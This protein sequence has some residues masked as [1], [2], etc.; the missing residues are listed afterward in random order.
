ML[1]KEFFQVQPFNPKVIPLT[2]VFQKNT[3]GNYTFTV[4]NQYNYVEI[5]I[6][7]AAGQKVC[8]NTN[9][10]Y[11]FLGTPGKGAIK[12]YLRT[13]TNHNITGIVGE[14]PTLSPG[15]TQTGGAGYNNG[16]N[17]S[18]N[19]NT[20]PW[21]GGGGGSTSFVCNGQLFTVGGGGGCAR[22]DGMSS[23]INIFS[24]N[25]GAG[26]GPNGGAA[27]YYSSVSTNQVINGKNATNSDTIGYN[28]NNG[29]VK[30]FAGFDPYL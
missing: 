12:R 22:R 19:S 26:G 5:E 13:L 16:S 7:G 21:G 3:P 8:Y 2:L 9:S 27:S 4:P 11:V 30:I 29:Y 25:G 14:Q 1:Q 24:V 10:G 20:G 6:A 28:S 17:G 23:T 15:N 18:S